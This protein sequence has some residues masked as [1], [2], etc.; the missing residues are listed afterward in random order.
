[1]TYQ[2]PAWGTGTGSS[3]PHGPRTPACPRPGRASA[4]GQRSGFSRAS[5]CGPERSFLHKGGRIPARSWQ[6]RRDSPRGPTCTR[7][8]AKGPQLSFSSAS[9]GLAPSL[10]GGQ[11]GD[12]MAPSGRAERSPTSI[13]LPPFSGA[14]LSVPGDK[15][16]F[17]LGVNGRPIR[18]AWQIAGRLQVGL[19]SGEPD[20]GWGSGA[21]PLPQPPRRREP[22]GGGGCPQ[23]PEEPAL[24]QAL[25]R[26]PSTPKVT[27]EGLATILGGGGRGLGFCQGLSLLSKRLWQLGPD[28]KCPPCEP[29]GRIQCPPRGHGQHLAPHLANRPCTTEVSVSWRLLAAGT[30]STATAEVAQGDP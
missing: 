2:E 7:R 24:G 12:R 18:R 29:P 13:N 14:S 23:G 10:P 25:A 1:M 6:G 5:L 4:L 26:G 19:P 22:Q 11:G 9:E 20:R 15:V 17:P 3:V 30:Q 28:H 21:S 27:L 16:F 8:G